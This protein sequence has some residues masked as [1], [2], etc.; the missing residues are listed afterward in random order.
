MS[1]TENLALVQQAFSYFGQKNIPA[2]LGMF[3]EDAQWVEPGDPASIPYAGTHTGAQGIMKMLGI[4]AHSIQMKS[5]V[6]TSFIADEEKVAVLGT[7][8]AVVIATGKPYFTD[9]MYI[10]TITD[11]KFSHLQVLMDTLAIANAFKAD[12]C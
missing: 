9:W 4:I 8:D 3:T 7:N 6:P 10:F 5:F 11:G 2:F 12:P 1:K